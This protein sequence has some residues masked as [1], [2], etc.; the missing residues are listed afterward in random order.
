[1]TLVNNLRQKLAEAEPREGRHDFQVVDAESGSAVS[2]AIE[3]RD[4]MSCLAQE[5]TVRRAAPANQDM[6]Q[7]A[8]AIAA[9]VTSLLQ[10]LQV[11]EIDTQRQQAL[12]RSTP[13]AP[14]QENPCYYEVLLDGATTATLRRFQATAARRTQAA[15]ALT[16]EGLVK[17]VG[18][19]LCA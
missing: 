9:R 3:K 14:N 15:F 16:H 17:L 6:G 18:D 13:P 12:L 4:A 8:A 11:L 19:L 1:M 7:W 10:P 5:I 2:I